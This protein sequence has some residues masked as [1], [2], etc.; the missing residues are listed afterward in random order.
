MRMIRSSTSSICRE[1]R[2]A[3]APHNQV[4][5]VAR[6][7]LRHCRSPLPQ[8]QRVNPEASDVCCLDSLDLTFTVADA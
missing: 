7:R 1:E 8:Q 2:L 3:G 6:A 5:A 4:C